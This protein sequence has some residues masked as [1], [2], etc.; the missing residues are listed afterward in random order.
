MATMTGCPDGDLAHVTSGVP[1]PATSW[2]DG[3]LTC[4]CVHW[5]TPTDRL[6]LDD[7]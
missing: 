4:E 1:P 6:G 7:F 2:R 3:Q 5:A